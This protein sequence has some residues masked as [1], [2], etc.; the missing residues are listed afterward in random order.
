METQFPVSKMSKESYAEREAKQSQTLTGLGKWWGRKPLVLCR[1]TILGLLLP[2]TDNPEKDREVFLR[3]MTMDDD[4]M[5]RRKSK[6]L[7]AA[8]IAERVLSAGLERHARHFVMATNRKGQ[9]VLDYRPSATAT[10]QRELYRKA[11]RSPLPPGEGQGVR[12]GV[13]IDATSVY[14]GS[15][16]ADRAAWFTDDSTDTHAEFYVCPET[17]LENAAF[18]SLSYDQRLQYCCRP[19]QIVGP[20]P[21]SWA[22]I[23]AHLG[24][25]AA[26][27]PELVKE[28]GQRRFGHTPRVGDSFC[29][30]GSI[31]FEAARIGCEAYGSDLNPVAALLTW[32]SLNIVG[33]GAEV[34]EEVRQAQRQVYDAVDRQITEWGIEHREPDPQTGRRWRA[35]AYLYCTEVTCPECGWRVPLAPSWVVGKGSKTIVR[36]IPD[37]KRKRFDFEVSRS[38]SLAR[39]SR[40]LPTP[41][42]PRTRNWSAPATSPPAS[43]VLRGPRSRPSAATAGEPLGKAE[44]SPRLGERRRR[45]PRGRHLWRAA[46][47]RSLGRYVDR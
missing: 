9:I 10:R 30:G 12:A 23:N 47:L 29:G 5:L 22:V 40:R 42:R 6:R 39:K 38:A 20:S 25:S 1:A 4:G 19:E 46:R 17:E 27:L 24:T 2:A 31:P 33:G 16:S 7:P 18:L 28:L 32:A 8:L 41:G 11:L 36:L 21:D 15:S 3:L 45:A 14:A 37:R 13:K 35:D 44:P 34:A 43:V 26:S